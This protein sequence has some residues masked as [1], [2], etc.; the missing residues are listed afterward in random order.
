M[1]NY[2]TIV[3]LAKIKELR[4]KDDYEKAYE[5]AKDVELKHVAHITDFSMIADVYSQMGD[6]EKA[7]AAYEK[8]YK[9]NNSRHALGEL[10]YLNIKLKD[11]EQARKLLE[12][13]EKI[14][15]KDPVRLIYEYRIEKLEK[16][17]IKQKIAT[18][19]K[20]KNE[21]YNERWGAE[22]CKLYHKDGND[23]RCL[24][25]CDRLILWFGE[26]EYVDW[27]K[28]LKAHLLGQINVTD[29][30]ES[31]GTLHYEEPKQP[32]V[33]YEEPKQTAVV[34]EEIKQ[35]V[36]PDYEVDINE[37][38]ISEE[39]TIPS[40]EEETSDEFTDAPDAVEYYPEQENTV[41]PEKTESISEAEILAVP[42]AE[43]EEEEYSEAEYSE[44]EYAEDEYTEEETESS[45][46]PEITEEPEV[47]SVFATVSAQNNTENDID[48]ADY[49]IEAVQYMSDYLA[50]NSSPY[51]K[52]RPEY[53]DVPKIGGQLGKQLANGSAVLEDF[54]GNYARMELVRKQLIRSL[55][56]IFDPLKRGDNI[57]ITGGPRTGKTTLAKKMAKTMNRFGVI[58][59]SKALLVGA[60]KMNRIDFV[61]QREN[62]ADCAIIIEKAG[63]LTKDTIENLLAI[64]AAYAGRTSII[65]EDER[66]NIN[67]LLRDNPEL[68]SVFNN[69]IHLPSEY[70]ATDLK[71]FV[72]EY[73]FEK[74]YDLEPAADEI[75]DKKL[76]RLVDSGSE[77]IIKD[78]VE[79][80]KQAIA[81]AEK[82]NAK[83]IAE[84]ALD[85]SF[86]NV[87]IMTI[88][89]EDFND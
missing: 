53:R 67:T 1:E 47:S 7:R 81:S 27:A 10:V 34:Y 13:Y 23:E 55:D 37:E 2:R 89:A 76:A 6:Y 44:E 33:R 25:E 68:N 54:F 77:D 83:V 66:K 52:L 30:S 63:K 40:F 15:P 59:S 70:K 84:I 14:A 12:E 50:K 4:S 45:P 51:I 29:A 69:R 41:S 78:A 26:G 16:A 42:G 21:D 49:E 22:L 85:G 9:K 35:P 36:E 80:A 82:R 57:I 79:I 39:E 48:K 38:L 3:A 61:K 46:E 58:K 75:I 19:E 65:L 86:E 73:L 18:L 28:T 17:P 5:I 43:P 56:M 74:E 24:E 20:W 8:L 11:A 60:D 72:F 88:R 71:G 87:D 31:S 64:S 62:L 32:E